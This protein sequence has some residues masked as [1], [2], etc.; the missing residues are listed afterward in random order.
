MF[1]RTPYP[2][3]SVIIC[4]FNEEKNLPYVLPRIPAWVD[5]ILLVDGHSTDKTIEVAK[6]LRPDTKV[7]YQ[8]DKGKGDALRHGFKHASGDIIVTLDADGAT[9]PGDM[10]KFIAPLLKGCDFAKGS[11]FA[12]SLP[13][14]KP[15]HRIFGNLL[16]AAI[17]NILYNSKY[18]D[19]CSGYNAFWRKVLEQTSFQSGDCFEDEP[20]FNARAK[21]AGLKVMEVGHHDLG[22]ISGGSKAPSWRQG[23]KAIKTLVRERLDRHML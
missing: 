18:T 1:P 4:T 3:I 13:A 9:D 16:I 19:I 22:R 17:F 23:L 2:K 20:L 11:R 7:L 6:K 10:P 5:E 14:N 12:L 21:R 8:P 15:L